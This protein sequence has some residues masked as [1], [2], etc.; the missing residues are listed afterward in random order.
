MKPQNDADPKPDDAVSPREGTI[1]S[2]DDLPVGAPPSALKEEG[3]EGSRFS[4]IETLI[5]HGG[6]TASIQ[7]RELVEEHTPVHRPIA[8]KESGLPPRLGRYQIA[9]QIARGGMGS[10]HRARDVDLGRDIAIKV[11]LDNHQGNPDMIR[12][13][14]EEAQISGQFQH[15]G[16]VPVHEMGL[17]GGKRPVAP[18]RGRSLERGAGDR[19]ARHAVPARP[20]RVLRAGAAGSPRG[21]PAGTRTFPPA[22]R[23]FVGATH[24]LRKPPL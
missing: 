3:D 18:S 1:S 23:R 16:I 4:V 11:L 6:V 21:Q 20:L 12:R 17:V 2:N 7:L 10:V 14:I 22:G 15:P 13:F 9:G 8:S 5:A 24:R 19:R